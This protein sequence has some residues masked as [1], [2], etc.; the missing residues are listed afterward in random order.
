MAARRETPN[1]RAALEIKYHPGLVAMIEGMGLACRP[2]EPVLSASSDPEARA[3]ALARTFRE[4]YSEAERMSVSY[5]EGGHAREGAI[6]LLGETAVEVARKAIAIA[7][8]W[9]TSP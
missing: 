7:E 1:L 4:A 2:L 8:A 5:T 3:A 9:I 6:I